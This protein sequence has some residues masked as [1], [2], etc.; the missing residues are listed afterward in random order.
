MKVHFHLFGHP[1]FPHKILDQRASLEEIIK[2]GKS[3]IR[4][5]DGEATIMEGGDLYFQKN[6]ACLMHTMQT[7]M[8]NYTHDSPYLIAVPPQML[9]SH[10]TQSEEAPDERWHKAKFQFSANLPSSNLPPL[11]DA[12]IFREDTSLTTD[13]IAKIWEPYETIFFVHSNYKYFVDFSSS[14]KD[15]DVQFINLYGA[16]SYVNVRSVLSRIDHH[17]DRSRQAS[18]PAIALVSGGPAGKVI[19]AA[20]SA[21]GV[22]AIDCGHYFDYKFYNI[23]RTSPF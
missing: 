14:M 16:N 7:I 19:V 1:P 12:M 2:T 11:L 20:L 17:E 6:T 22:R 23:R 9:K 15:K 8:R 18:K 13:E 10:D 5:G 21:R 3:L 4:F